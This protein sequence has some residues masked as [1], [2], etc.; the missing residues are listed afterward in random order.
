MQIKI[1]IDPKTSTVE[2]E[3]V[4]AEGSKCTDIT[5][6]LMKGRNVID[7]HLTSEYYVP[8]VEPVFNSND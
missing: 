3:V 8:E 7:E 6:V 4:G 1:K 5:S 2:Y